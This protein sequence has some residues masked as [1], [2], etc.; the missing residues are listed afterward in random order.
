[1]V[2]KIPD[3][4]R[5]MIR[6]KSEVLEPNARLALQYAS[7]EG[8]EFLSSVVARLLDTEQ[9]RVEEDLVSLAQNHG[10]I[11]VHGEEE[12]PD[13]AL[14]TR[15]AF[16]HALYQ[17]VFYEEIVASRRTQLHAIAGEQLLNHYGDLAPRIAG[18][19]AMHFERGRNWVRAVEFL[20]IAAGNARNMYANSEAEEHYTHAIEISGRLAEGA[21]ADAQ[22]RIYE[23]RAL[24]Y[25]ATSRFD[26]SIA[27]GRKMI[28]CA[29]MAG[30]AELE[31]AALYSLGNTLFWSHRLDEMQ[32]T[33]EEVLRVSGANEAGRMRALALMGQGHLASGDLSSVEDKLR[34]LIQCSPSLDKET[35]L[36]VLD[37]GARLSFFRSEY[38]E[39]EQLF[40][41]QIELASELSNA[42][43][44]VK[45]NYFLGLTLANLGRVSE[46]LA[47]LGSAMDIAKRN[48]EIFWLSRMPNAFGWIHREMQDFEGAKAFDREGAAIGHKAG[49]GEAEI[50]SV[51][52]LAIDYL[53]SNDEATVCSAMKSA[54]SLLSHDAWFRWRFEIRLL[55]ARAEQTLA[56]ADAIAL[57]D[58]ATQHRAHKYMVIART[59]LSRI[60]MHSADFD[61]AAEEITAA[62]SMLKRYP[63]LLCAWQAHAMLGRIEMQCGDRDSGITAYR[64]AVSNIRYIADHVD[65]ERLRCIFLNSDAIREVLRDADEQRCAE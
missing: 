65:D 6:Q 37:L 45:G 23:K 32:S 62:C 53:H 5:A 20:M 50:N 55:H 10:L 38:E 19:L 3:S 12:L 61:T 17:N 63:A 18:Q 39:A 2:Q 16:A 47:V 21:R 26:L 54:E 64:L 58:K 29:R 8:E 59:L 22:F 4:V 13:G 43:E 24:V 34:T 44:L 51:I 31:C 27:D 35:L 15:Y 46:A 9:L 52:N 56:R 36:G 57:L 33:L 14:V 41:K 40:R 28:Q 11:R 25:L 1:M 48:G 42:F 60:A 49:F 30:S 7:I